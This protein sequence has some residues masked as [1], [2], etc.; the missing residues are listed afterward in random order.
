MVLQQEDRLLGEDVT[1]VPIGHF[2]ALSIAPF[3]GCDHRSIDGNLVR[4]A[5]DSVTIQ[6]YDTLQKRHVRRQIS[7]LFDKVPN[8]IRRANK[9][10]IAA[11]DESVIEPIKADGGAR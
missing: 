10:V 4:L 6:T 3:R 5:T 9:D 1:A 8:P 2:A 11:L 7:A